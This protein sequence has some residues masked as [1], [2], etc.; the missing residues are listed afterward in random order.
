LHSDEP[1]PSPSGTVGSSLDRRVFLRRTLTGLGAS[2]VL[3]LPGVR[4]V[5]AAVQKKVRTAY[6]LSTHGRRV[7]SACRSHAANRFYISADAAN[8][9]RPHVGCN[10]GIVTQ[11]LLKGT[12]SCYF[13]GGRAS[14]YDLRWRKPKCPPP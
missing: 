4:H 7:C 1:V 8:T 2:A 3:S 10:C 14:V 6:R 12:W 9:G 13:R 5:E 11:D